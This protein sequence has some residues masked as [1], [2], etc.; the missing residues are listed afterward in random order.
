MHNGHVATI[1][2]FKGNNS[3]V[4]NYEKLNSLYV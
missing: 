4:K 3:Q 1:N 2:T